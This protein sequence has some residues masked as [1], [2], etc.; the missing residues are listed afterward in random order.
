MPAMDTIQPLPVTFS[1]LLRHYTLEEFWA[2]PEPENRARYELIEGMLFMTP[3]PDPPHGDIASRLTDLLVTFLSSHGRPGNVYHPREP[4]YINGTYLEPDMMYVSHEL[5]ARMG[6]RRTS[7]DLV[8]EYLS[9][10]TAT[11]DRTTKADTYLALGVRELWL[12]DPDTVTM[13]VRR[14]LTVNETNVFPR[15]E[16]LT[17]TTGQWAASRVLAGWRVSVDELFWDSSNRVRSLHKFSIT[18]GS[19]GSASAKPNTRE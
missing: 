3:P 17:Y 16:T 4:I 13:E 15:W 11:Y 14:A 18:T 5:W 12:V 7:A 2:L 8:F 1:P 9:T 6:A 19:T 10:R